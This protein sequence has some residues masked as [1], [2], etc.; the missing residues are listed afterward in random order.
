MTCLDAVDRFDLDHI[1]HA[2]ESCRL[3]EGSGESERR[4]LV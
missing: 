4:D 1:K 2:A 3:A